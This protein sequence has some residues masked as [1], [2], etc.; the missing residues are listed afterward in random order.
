M[1]KYSKLLKATPYNSVKHTDTVVTIYHECTNRY[2]VSRIDC[3]DNL[4]C[5][6]ND[7]KPL[8]YNNNKLLINIVKTIKI[9][10]TRVFYIPTNN[11]NQ[12]CNNLIL[13]T[14]IESIIN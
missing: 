3:N 12:W 2:V 13:K 9:K 11:Y 8:I 7:L 6:K 1:I 14:K 4:I 5:T 10:N